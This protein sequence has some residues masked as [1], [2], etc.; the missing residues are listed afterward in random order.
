MKEIQDRRSI[1][2]FRTDNVDR[3][4]IITIL[5]AGML[6]PSAKNRQPWRFIVYSGNSKDEILGV[7]EKALV[8]ERDEYMT[9][10]HSYCGLPDAFNTL[11]IMREAP[12]IIFIENTNGSSPFKV[13]NAD[14]RVCEICDTLSVGA[15]VENILLTA[16]EM[17]YGTLWI[18]NTCYA[19]SELSEHIGIK[20]QL[21]GAVALGLP[22]ECPY[23]RPRRSADEVIEFR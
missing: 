6:A 7:M 10:P 18:A 1:R 9:L 14:E 2:K 15:A 16:N 22:A 21:T 19:Y 3:E 5:R 13:Q 8:L 4:D 20:G 23:P 12:V 11:R 17:G